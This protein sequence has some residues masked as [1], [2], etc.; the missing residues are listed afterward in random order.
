MLAL[1][2]GNAVPVDRLVDALWGE[3]LPGDDRPPRPAEVVVQAR[4]SAEIRQSSR[5]GKLPTS[6]PLTARRQLPS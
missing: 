5:V 4:A 1:E 2:A 3:V 6:G